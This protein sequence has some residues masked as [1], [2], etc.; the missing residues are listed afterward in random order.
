MPESAR[1]ILI[2]ELDSPAQAQRFSEKGARAAITELT[3]MLRVGVLVSGSILVTDAML[4]DGEYFM[5]LGPEGVLN[6]LGATR[7]AF[8]LTITGPDADLRAGLDRR[9]RNPDFRWSMAAARDGQVSREILRRW[10]AWIDLVESGTVRYE[11]QL[12]VDASLRTGEPPVAS[13]QE[14]LLIEHA[15]LG[16]ERYRSEAWRKIDLL[17]VDDETRQRIRA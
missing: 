17:D 5:T 15:R 11:Q 3:G 8:P 14:R 12:S 6:E 9:R 7:A 1:R 16:E 10:D 4:L 13:E 2:A